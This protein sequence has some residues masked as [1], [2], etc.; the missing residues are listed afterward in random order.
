MIQTLGR[1]HGAAFLRYIRM[2]KS[3]LAGASATLAQQ[4]S[5]AAGAGSSHS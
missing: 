4:A 3:R 1:W 5:Q 2:L